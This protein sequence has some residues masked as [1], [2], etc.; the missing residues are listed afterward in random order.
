MKKSEIEIHRQCL[1]R[2]HIEAV[3]RDT[4]NLQCLRS[5]NESPGYRTSPLS[6]DNAY[7][8]GTGTERMANQILRPNLLFQTP[9]V[10]LPVTLGDT[11]PIL[12]ISESTYPP[13]LCF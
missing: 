10:S 6:P 11:A 5:F 7:H 9:I 13:S 4:V 1:S 8:D 3:T 2:L 12:I